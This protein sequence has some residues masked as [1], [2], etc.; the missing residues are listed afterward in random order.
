[1]PY[2]WLLPDI[3]PNTKNK[4]ENTLFLKLMV[5]KAEDDIIR[6]ELEEKYDRLR[7]GGI[8][9]HLRKNKYS[10]WRICLERRV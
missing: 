4:P 3:V 1:M 7:K 6:K 2:Q 10:G 8:V 5:Q 9:M